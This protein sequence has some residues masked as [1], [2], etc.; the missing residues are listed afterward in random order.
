MKNLRLF[1]LAS[2]VTLNSG[3]ALA[4]IIKVQGMSCG[5]CE[6][7]VR[8]KVCQN[9]EIKN[10]MSSCDAKVVDADKEVGELRYTL[11]PDVK[12]DADKMSKIEKAVADTGRS[13][14]KTP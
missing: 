2:L 9:S 10:W 7:Q 14:I 4:D 12:L 6:K 5:G 3:L 11:K 13:V 8:A 1:A